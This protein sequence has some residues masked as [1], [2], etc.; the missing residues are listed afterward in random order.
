MVSPRLLL[1]LS[2]A[3]RWLEQL[4]QGSFG[5]SMRSSNFPQSARLE[6][7]ARTQK[8]NTA[9][10]GARVKSRVD[11]WSRDSRKDLRHRRA[12]LRYITCKV[13]KRS[14]VSECPLCF[15]FRDSR[16]TPLHYSSK[17]SPHH[18]QLRCLRLQII[19]SPLLP[20]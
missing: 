5:V 14:E 3:N 1:R 11:A 4:E 9:R 6:S 12:A 2:T 20:R 13:V 10:K 19:P 15:L 8:L 7:R 16:L 18:R 17:L